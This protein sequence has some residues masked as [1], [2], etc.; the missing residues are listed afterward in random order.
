MC[1]WFQGP[2]CLLDKLIVA[3]FFLPLVFQKQ[4]SVD[5]DIHSD[6][7][8]KISGIILSLS[9]LNYRPVAV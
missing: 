3:S 7:P 6:L 5:V 9:G 1:K 2:A 8:E 4:S